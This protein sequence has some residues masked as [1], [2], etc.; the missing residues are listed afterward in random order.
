VRVLLTL[1]LLQRSFEQ[2]L[3]TAASGKLYISWT[4]AAEKWIANSNIWR[5]GDGQK[6]YA[7]SLRVETIESS[8]GNETWQQR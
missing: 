7:T 3:K 4:S 1:G 6:T 5:H 8:I 2:Q